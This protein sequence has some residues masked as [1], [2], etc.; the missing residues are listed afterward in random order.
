[1]GWILLGMAILGV[2][3]GVVTAYT[4]RSAF[5]SPLPFAPWVTWLHDPINWVLFP[6]GLATFFFLLFP[7]GHLQTRR[8]RWFGWFAMAIVV[9][10]F[11]FFL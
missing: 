4:F 6:A 7:D 9:V 1:M 3:S 8:W 2:L 10:G 11:V 5:F